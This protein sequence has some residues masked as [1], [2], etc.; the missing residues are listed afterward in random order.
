L[1]A[2]I[3]ILFVIVTIITI[4]LAVQNVKMATSR[5]DPISCPVVKGQFAILPEISGAPL[6]ECTDSID[7]KQC[8]YY[9]LKN[10]KECILKCNQLSNI[11]NVFSYVSKTNTFIILDPNKAYTPTNNSNVYVRQFL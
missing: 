9:G 7:G 3:T 1:F 2:I 8:I 4:F 11:C 10:M 6:N 5:I